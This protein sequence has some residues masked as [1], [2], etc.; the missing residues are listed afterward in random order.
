MSSND[1]YRKFFENEIHI[2]YEYLFKFLITVTSDS[3]LA[4][5]IT[6]DTMAAAWANIQRVYRYSNIKRALLAIARNK[7]CDHYRKNNS[8]DKIMLLAKVIDMPF[9]VEDNLFHILK[10]EER[11]TILKAIENLKEPYMQV[12]LLR[13][14]YN[15]SFRNVAKLMNANYNTI[16]SR[17]RRALCELKRVLRKE[18]S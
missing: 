4:G 16:L 14:Y 1:P 18:G 2:H 9:V 3:S 15:Q 8:Y 11:R 6:Q 13:Y 12:I 17:H 5:D 7:L 10:D